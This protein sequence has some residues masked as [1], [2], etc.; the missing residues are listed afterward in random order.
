MNIT[1]VMNHRLFVARQFVNNIPDEVN[2]KETF[3]CARIML[4]MT[5]YVEF[6]RNY[7]MVVVN[8]GSK[9]FENSEIGHNKMLKYLEKL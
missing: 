8:S 2:N 9:M 4:D 6:D 1:Q 3:V 5:C 7:I